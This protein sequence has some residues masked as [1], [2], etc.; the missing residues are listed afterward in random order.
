[1]RI[2]RGLLF[3]GVALV[4]AG[5]VALAVGQGWIDR[6]AM[7]ELWRLW[8][9]ILVALGVAI[10]LSRTPLA[11]LGILV[12][13]L[14]VGAAAGAALALGPG[15]VAACGVRLQVAVE[16]ST[17]RVDPRAGRV[18]VDAEAAQPIR[19]GD[20]PRLAPDAERAALRRAQ[21]QTAGPLL[22]AR[23]VAPRI[24][25]PSIAGSQLEPIRGN[26]LYTSPAFSPATKA[27]QTIW[28]ASR[29]PS[30]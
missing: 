4:V 15:V 2:N 11:A 20:P 16:R 29:P 17:R 24:E 27:P 12:A 30:T 1:M 3:W 18:G 6:Q 19:H 22:D 5:V 8:P 13:A 10:V 25:P 23:L 28:R 9:L 21:R 14:V 26:V 7:L